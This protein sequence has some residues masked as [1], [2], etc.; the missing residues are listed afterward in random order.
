MK[1]PSIATKRKAAGIAAIAMLI[2]LSV[3][4]YECIG[5][6][7]NELARDTQRLRLWVNERGWHARMLYAAAVCFQVV[8]AIIPGEPLELGAG[9]AFGPWEGTL[10]C[11][12]GIAVGSALVFGLVRRFGKRLVSIYFSEEKIESIKIIRDPKKSTALLMALMLLPGTPKDL[13]TYCAGLT[14]IPWG[15]WM[16]ICTVG[17]IPSVITSTLGGH[18][19]AEGRYGQA[20]I[21]FLCTLL[22]CGAGLYL[23]AKI[24]NRK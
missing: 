17:R 8:V 7:M 18:A 13:L 16:L 24:K 22:L 6:P 2:A 3:I 20:A 11:L 14:S 5:K 9:F 19:V 1:N 4:A 12:A 15:T 23:Y 10:V 21:I